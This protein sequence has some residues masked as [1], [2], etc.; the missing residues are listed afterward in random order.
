MKDSSLKLTFCLVLPYIIE[1]I[2]IFKCLRKKNDSNDQI[3]WKKCYFP[4]SNSS[5]SPRYFPVIFVVTCG[6][7]L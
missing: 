2:P 4:C 5:P 7:G 3:P 1:I 6:R